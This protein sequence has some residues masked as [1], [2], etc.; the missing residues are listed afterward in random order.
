MAQ[1]DWK[2]FNAGPSAIEAMFAGELDLTY[3][4]PNPAINGYIK[5][6][7][8]ALRI[9]CGAN[10]GGAGLVV[11][12]DS[13]INT[14]ED[15][16]GKKIASP[17]LGNTQD[18]ALRIFLKEKGFTLKEKGGDVEVIPIKNPDQLA[19]F[20][21]KELDGAWTV[22][23]W[24]AR[25]IL[26]GNGRLFLDEKECW[27]DGDYVTTHLIV[28]TKFLTEH[29]DLVKKWIEAHV[30][31][32]DWI[33]EHPEEAKAS[34]NAEIAKETGKPL[35]KD[36]LDSAFSRCGITFDPIKKSLLKSA[37]DAY[38]LGFLG[39]KKPDLSYIYDLKILNSVLREKNKHEI[40]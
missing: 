31:L 34:L 27:Q 25:L 36:V 16:H 23:P 21:K 30:E 39:D 7:G 10:S 20:I 6:N 22:E 1:I 8:T 38:Q 12:K 37:E 19:L 3:I 24:V 17:Q 5:S 15:L 13:G 29:P 9:I 26:E 33:N 14:V 28:R 32:T 4:G 11:R 35:P 40:D 18:V 2:V